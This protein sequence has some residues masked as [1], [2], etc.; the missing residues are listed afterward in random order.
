MKIKL[1]FLIL[2]PT[3]LGFSQTIPVNFRYTTTNQTVTNIYIAGSFNSW[4]GSD[5]N[6]KLSDSNNDGI[7]DIILNLNKGTYQYKFV[8]DFTWILDPCNPVTGGSQNENSQITVSDPMVTYLLP[9]DTIEY[10]ISQPP[11][12][13]A[14]VAF[15]TGATVNYSNLSLKINNI[16]I[17]LSSDNYNQS[18]KTFT[19]QPIAS[20]LA[21]GVNNIEFKIST[22]SGNAVKTTSFKV[23]RLPRFNLLTEDMIYF[24]PNIVV[25]G[26]ILDFPI[27]S[28]RVNFNGNISLASIRADSIF[29]L[30]VTLTDGLNNVSVTMYNSMGAKIKTQTL[31]YQANKRPTVDVQA[32]LAGRTVTM[33]ANATSPIG[34]TLSYL[35]SQPDNGP[36]KLIQNKLTAGTIQVTIPTIIGDYFIKVKVTDAK[37]NFNFGGCL[38]RSTLDA[39][40]IVSPDEQPAWIK[41]IILYEIVPLVY[42][43]TTSPLAGI[44]AKLDYIAGL[45]VNTIWLTP[46]FDGIGN[47]Y[48]VK[49]YYKISTTQ[50][51]L[52]ELKEL[53]NKAHSKGL[54][55]LLDLPINHSWTEHPFFKNV[56]QLKSMS[57]FADYYLWSGT[58]G[59]S[60][61]NYYYNWFFLPNYNVNNTDLKNYLY[62]VAEYWLRECDIDGYRCDVAWGVEERNPTFWKEMRTRLKKIKPD[63]FLLGE[64]DASNINEGTPI[65]IFNKK[66]DAAY[67]WN[68][69]KWTTNT[70]LPGIINGN[71]TIDQLNNIV[72]APFPANAYPMRFIDNHDHDRAASE[73]GIPKTKLAEAIIFTING[74]PLIYAGDEMG[75]K[76]QYN[77]SWNDPSKVKP[78]FQKLIEIR[79]KYLNNNTKVVRLTNT[80]ANNVYSYIAKSDTNYILTTA[81]FSNRPQIF[82]INFTSPD[83]PEKEYEL[84]NLFT[85]TSAY[86]TFNKLQTVT[87]SLNPLEANVFKLSTSKNLLLNG[88]FSD[89]QDYWSNYTNTGTQA[90]FNIENNS[91]VANV[92][93]GGTNPWDVQY[94][95]QNILIEKGKIFD[96]LFDASSAQT[97]TINIGVGENTGDYSGYFI[98]TITLSTTM[99]TYI[100]TATMTNETDSVARFIIEFGGQN[101]SV[102]MDN[103]ILREHIELYLAVSTNSFI[104]EAAANSQKTFTITSNT[105]WL[106]TSDQTWLTISR[107]KGSNNATITLTALAN[108]TTAPRTA[109]VEVSG[110]FS[111]TVLTP[112][113]ITVTQDG[114]P[115]TE[116]PDIVNADIKLYPNP[117]NNF[118]F[119]EGLTQHAVITISDL[120]GE[121]LINTGILNNQINISNLTKGIYFIKI[122]DK[123]GVITKKFLKY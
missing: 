39:V 89:N 34:Q 1:L 26:K 14:I 38:I 16:P 94:I 93:N 120:N 61:Y 22:A 63:I 123:S 68:L 72:T 48:W 46:I 40:S 115:I 13:A 4:S 5:P 12:I 41:K 111:G 92:I 79:S 21:E 9:Y 50:G 97:R 95:Q 20:Q 55:L 103:I 32:T 36:S 75:E 104:I 19:Y 62:G 59:A 8:V 28:V 105:N 53:V 42:N 10:S 117:A 84:I 2:I 44:T 112:K 29:Y 76:I 78:Y 119:I 121:M 100:F 70:G 118:L 25:Y 60:S 35:W 66:F 106:L 80:Q 6:Y 56:T 110:A 58:P 52:E 45:G 77:M 18:T 82:S 81:N 102:N 31:N 108:P 71:I 116:F 85:D 30:P 90:S 122:V 51:T 11:V 87:F 74:I 54:K 47:G 91:L 33:N 67:D 37:G 107:D 113:T 7:Y 49:D 88:T 99:Q 83:I 23:T 109:T 96:I 15:G 101:V 86:L 43:N 73:F 69:R 57:P 65:D 24:K 27:D 17:S 3:Q 98:R 114:M 64:A